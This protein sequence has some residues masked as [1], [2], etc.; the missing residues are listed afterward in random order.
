MT[1]EQLL[2]TLLVSIVVLLAFV[3]MW[4]N[5]AIGW[6]R[7]YFRT[8]DHAHSLMRQLEMRDEHRAREDRPDGQRPAW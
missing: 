8:S 6:R 1:E 4:V 2:L 3:F 5:I 7:L